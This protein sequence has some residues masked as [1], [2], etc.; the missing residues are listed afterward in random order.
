M[1]VKI[2]LAKIWSRKVGL[3]GSQNLAWLEDQVGILKADESSEN[4]VL[5]VLDR[6]YGE[7]CL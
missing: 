1:V 5:N 4:S 6:D 2:T 3:A 7:I